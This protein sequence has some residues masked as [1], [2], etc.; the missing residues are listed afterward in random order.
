MAYCLGHPVYRAF[1][2]ARAKLQA[3][4]KPCSRRRIRDNILA[5][6]CDVAKLA[7]CQSSYRR[8]RRIALR[9]TSG[10]PETAAR[11]CACLLHLSYSVQ[12]TSVVLKPHTCNPK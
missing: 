2:C 12:V 1:S 8:P 11:L 4:F 9:L 6:I 3:K 10:Q 7:V 5:V